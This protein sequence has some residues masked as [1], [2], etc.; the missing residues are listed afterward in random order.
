[1]ALDPWS[2]GKAAKC[3]TVK[4]PG[5]VARW[6][7]SQKLPGTIRRR[8]GTGECCD[9]H[10]SRRPSLGVHYPDGR[11]G[12]SGVRE[13]SKYS[14]KR[15]ETSKGEIPGQSTFLGI[16]PGQL[17]GLSC[18]DAEEVEGSNPSGP[19]K[20]TPGK[21]GSSAI[22]VPMFITLA[23]AGGCKSGTLRRPNTSRSSNPTEMLIFHGSSTTTLGRSTG[24]FC[25][26]LLVL[27][28]SVG[29]GGSICGI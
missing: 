22:W 13:R 18:P 2:R 11:P 10:K 15:R 8:W 26:Y 4:E 14:E 21:R 7:E 9:G 19:T 3:D 12:P 29:Y 6:S 24:L 17:G 1:M 5:G 20:K 27:M 23:S 16:R 25:G 28:C